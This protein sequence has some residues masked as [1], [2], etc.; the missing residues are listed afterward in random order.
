MIIYPAIDLREGQCVQLVGGDYNN[1]LI[2]IPDPIAVAKDWIR[3]GFDHLHIIDLDR[4][5]RRGSNI[6]VVKEIASLSKDDSDL[7]I[8][9]G[10]GVRSFEDIDEIFEAGAKSIVVGTK[11]IVDPDWFRE[12]ARK[13]PYRLYVAVE[14]EVRKVRVAG[15]QEDS[16]KTL[17]EII[18]EFDDL[19]LAGVFVTAIHVEGRR[20]GT[21][22]ELFSYIRSI[23]KLPIVAS[24][25]ITTKG[26]VDALD[27]AGINEIVLGAAIYTDKNLANVLQEGQYS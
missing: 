25:G 13:Y 9:V 23:T 1:E 5:T 7:V 15:W 10:G 22:Q 24:G 11:A 12:C 2:R 16:E 19:Q 26:D 8:R 4:A 3:Q 18:C 6:E 17:E 27:S 20:E 14:V 21:D